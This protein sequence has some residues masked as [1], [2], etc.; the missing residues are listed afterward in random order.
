MKATISDAQG[1]LTIKNSIVFAAIIIASVLLIETV[2]YMIWRRFPAPLLVFF[3]AA[4]LWKIGRRIGHSGFTRILNA[5]SVGLAVFAVA[6]FVAA[7]IDGYYFPIQGYLSWGV[8]TTMLGWIAFHTWRAWKVLRDMNPLHLIH[9]TEGTDAIFAQM[10]YRE[11][12]SR[13]AREEFEK[14]KNHPRVSA[15]LY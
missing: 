11:I 5:A 6:L 12:R 2:G 3:I 14:V 7:T 9:V 13:E 1:A 10:T 4:L 15:H 8:F